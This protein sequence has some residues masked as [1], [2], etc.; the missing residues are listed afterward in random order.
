[1]PL[2]KSKYKT[3]FL[4]KN[5]HLQSI[6]PAV[7]RKVKDVDYTRERIYTPDDDFL[8]LDWSKKSN[9]KLIILVPGLEASSRTKYILGMI[10]VFNK[11]LWST[12]VFNPRGLS[13]EANNQ[14]IQYHAGKT[15]DFHLALEH[16]VSKNIYKSIVIV[17]FSFGANMI[18]KYLGEEKYNIPQEIEKVTCASVTCDI[19][20]SA[21]K[22]D[23]TIYFNY[24]MGKFKKNIKLKEEKFPEQFNLKDWNKI[25]N[26][27]QYIERYVTA[28]NEFKDAAE[29]WYTTSCMHFLKNI[30]IPT[31]II[32]SK[33]DPFLTEKSYPISDAENNF[34]LYIELPDHGGH[35]GF[36]LFNKER[37]YYLEKRF[38]EFIENDGL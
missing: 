13:G 3:P 20:A 1:M 21:N 22:L 11:R 8:D 25:K 24:F 27:R 29:Y 36:I 19:T 17:G 28:F 38:I 30:K 18:L 2:I 16:I 23:G 32:N 4:F 35:N 10:H 37:E 34:Y 7:F 12:V 14:L 26:F 5:K 33:D 9:E 31:L 6:F 15:D